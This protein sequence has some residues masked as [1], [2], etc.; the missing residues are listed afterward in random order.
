MQAIMR[1]FNF[2][3]SLLGGP[4]MLKFL[5][6]R[7]LSALPVLFAIMVVTFG[8]IRAMPGGP[9]DAVNQ[10]S[11]PDHIRNQLEQRYG[12][13][14][15]IFFDNPAN[16]KGAETMWGQQL[17]VKGGYGE[18]E[19]GTYE[20]MDNTGL[21]IYE[22]FDLYRWD[23]EVQG[24]REY[25]EHPYQDW[26]RDNADLT[27]ALGLVS[28]F[29]NA[30]SGVPAPGIATTATYLNTNT[31]VNRSLI[32]LTDY[33]EDCRLY[34]SWPG[35]SLISRR[36]ECI[37]TGGSV[38]FTIDEVND[39]YRIDPMDSQFWNYFWG[40]L[41]LDFGPSLNI[42][43][44]R[45]NRQVSEEIAN[46]LP[47]SM[48]VGVVAVIFGFAL[49]IPLGVLAA[50]FHNTTIDYVAT[51]FA[52]LGRSTPNIVLAPLLIIVFAVEIEILPTPQREVWVETS[53]FNKDHLVALILP[54]IA[55]GTGMSA[56]IARLTRASLLQV[57][58]EDYIRTAR[59][60]GLRERTVVYLHAL[61]NSLIPV[62]TI[63]GPLLA[64]LLTGTFVIELI[65]LIPGLGSAFI[66]GVNA[67]DYTTIM[68][69]TLLYS[70]FLIAG[71]ILVDV[72]YTWLDPRIRF[73]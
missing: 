41:Q 6:R 28:S 60:K 49:G 1:V 36:E 11:M 40:V 48:E 50:I 66:D 53:F 27:Q 29:S 31:V 25:E 22:D 21:S 23:E 69:V 68:A 15:S 52:V 56:G 17:W 51:F 71:N 62:A 26:A 5:V 35:W 58:N 39:G 70:T 33:L 54:T 46:R 44:L 7:I 20:P 63:L 13:N 30:V 10:R 14:K 2:L 72:I 19:T 61:K 59:A 16:A 32:Q 55:L 4:S 37:N 67:R 18:I 38:G 8:L 9:F 65:F 34:K 47:V 57:L 73:D 3:I 12:L 24:L 45:E 43:E 64:A 42:A